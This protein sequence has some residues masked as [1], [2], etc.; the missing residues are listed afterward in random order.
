MNVPDDNNTGDLRPLTKA[1]AAEMRRDSI[2][3]ES[4]VSPVSGVPVP[5]AAST[6]ATRHSSPPGEE[7]VWVERVGTSATQKL[8]AVVGGVAMADGVHRIVKGLSSN[9]K[10]GKRDL[11]GAALGLAEAGIGTTLLATA[12]ASACKHTR[13]R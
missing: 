3:V 6:M 4:T 8:Q 12:L 9:E 13:G 11:A 1:E 2:P 7:A 10:T 5:P